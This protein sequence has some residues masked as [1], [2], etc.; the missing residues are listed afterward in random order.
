[1]NKVLIHSIIA[2]GDST[3][4]LGLGRCSVSTLIQCSVG[5]TIQ[6]LVCPAMYIQRFVVVLLG[7]IL[8]PSESSS[9]QR[10]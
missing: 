3:K 1:M 10:Q 5:H 9:K 6:Y 2:T 4:G 8:Q 7:R